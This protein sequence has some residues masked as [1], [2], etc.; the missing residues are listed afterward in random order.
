MDTGWRR[1]KQLAPQAHAQLLALSDT[2]RQLSPLLAELVNVLC[3]YI[4]GCAFCVQMHS[5][6]ALAQGATQAQLEQLALWPYGA[7]DVF[8]VQ[9]NT[10]F[11][12]ARA[13]TQL[14]PVTPWPTLRAAT[15][16]QFSEQELAELD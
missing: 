2:P 11:G 4:N 12:W 9:Q 8:D 15:L 14:A 13:I 10:A 7:T 6:A 5:K 1:F 3:S 16:S